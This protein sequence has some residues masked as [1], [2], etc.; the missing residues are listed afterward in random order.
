MDLV[1]LFA[2]ILKSQRCFSALVDKLKPSDF[3]QKTEQAASFMATTLKQWKKTNENCPTRL[4]VEAM[5]KHSVNTLFGTESHLVIKGLLEFVDVCYAFPDNELNEEHVINNMFNGFV[6]ERRSQVVKSTVQRATSVKDFLGSMDMLRDME[7]QVQPASNIQVDLFAEDSMKVS[8]PKLD[9]GLL[10]VDL[11]TG[12]GIAKGE[13]ACLLGWTSGGKTMLSVG[14]ICEGV[15]RKRHVL[16][17]SYE[18]QVAG[19]ELGARFQGYFAGIP[20][21]E[22]DAYVQ[23]GGEYPDPVKA[24]LREA[25][26]RYEIGKYMHILDFKQPGAANNG[27]ATLAS[28]VKDFR[29]KGTPIDLVVIDQLQPMVDSWLVNENKEVEANRRS[30]MSRVV[31]EAVDLSRKDKLNF[32][33]VIVH[34][35]APGFKTVSPYKR[36]TQGMAAEDKSIENWAQTCLVLGKMDRNKM[37]WFSNVKVRTGEAQDLVL[38][39]DPQNYRFLCNPDKYICNGEAFIEKGAKRSQWQAE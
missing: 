16:Y 18:T 17:A 9:T 32:G 8:N 1:L 4:W 3:N 33:C 31:T 29:E 15:M 2:H 13:V 14:L 25:R 35:V 20:K 11:L 6:W 10:H 22:M 21:N 19:T 37:C 38:K 26:E 23:A 12:G 36:L 28:A 5:L 30:Y 24:K 27:M 7:R 39:Y 34:Q